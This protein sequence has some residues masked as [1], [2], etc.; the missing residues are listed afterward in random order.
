MSE[1]KG[2]KGPWYPVEYAG[3]IVIQTLDYYSHCHDILNMDDFTENQVNA[4]AKLISKAPEM[5]EMLKLIVEA[6]Y[7]KDGSLAKLNSTISSAKNLIKE[8]TEI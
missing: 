4:N 5:L 3:R 1:F 8:A 7:E 2:T 6:Q